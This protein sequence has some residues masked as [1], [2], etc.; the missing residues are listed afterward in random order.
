MSGIKEY[1]LGLRNRFS[2]KKDEFERYALNY[3]EAGTIGILFYDFTQS[4]KSVIAS[5]VDKLRL[6]GKKVKVLIYSEEDQTEVIGRP[7]PTFT[8]KEISVLGNIQS[9]EVLDFTDESFDYLFCLYLKHIPTFDYILAK[10][11][12]KLR[13][14]KYFENSENYLD[15]M[16]NLPENASF[17]TLIEMMLQ[18]T[19]KLN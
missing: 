15:L 16:L 14:G 11:K 2:S 18:Y 6:E 4:Q 17:A 13:I 9:Q 10:S 7:F 3:E 19:K 1:F 5:F 12:A 8:Q